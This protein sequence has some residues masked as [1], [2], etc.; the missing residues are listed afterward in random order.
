MASEYQPPI[1]PA[2]QPGKSRATPWILGGCALLLLLLIV[3]GVGGYGFYRWKLSATGA[4]AN[5]PESPGGIE[6]ANRSEATNSPTSS[7]A[8][9]S[10][11]PAGEAK[12]DSWATTASSSTDAA[13]TRSSFTCTAHGTKHSVW[14]SDVYTA[15]SSICT[16]AVHAGLITIDAGG[17]VTIELRPGRPL[18]GNSDRNGV[19]TSVYGGFGKSF[20][21]PAANSDNAVK[22]ADEVT[23]VT[24]DITTVMLSFEPGKKVK[25]KCPANGSAKKIW[26]T[27]VYTGDSSI[28]TAAVHAGVITLDQGGLVTIELKPG[29][30]SYKGTTRNGVTSIDYGS[31][32]ASFSVK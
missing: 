31:Y 16:A 18:Y 11:Q 12:P 29:Q 1:S 21:F 7:N 5:H 24:W 20:V 9:S 2:P 27:D 32:G 26:G 15:D 28:C 8:N 10:I 17:T 19:T 14:G 23:P 4:N 30:T 25:F 13:G 3:L 6:N 22:E